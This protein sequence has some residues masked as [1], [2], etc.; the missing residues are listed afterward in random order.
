MCVTQFIETRDSLIPH[1]SFILVCNDN[2][3]CMRSVSAGNLTLKLD[4]AGLLPQWDNIHKIVSHADRLGT[5]RKA[6]PSNRSVE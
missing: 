4:M 6:T 2:V 1:S 5:L 3:C